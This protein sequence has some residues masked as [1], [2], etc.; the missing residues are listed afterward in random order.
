MSFRHP[1]SRPLVFHFLKLCTGPHN[2]C[3]WPASGTLPIFVT[4]RLQHST[5]FDKK[6]VHCEPAVGVY[7]CTHLKNETSGYSA[8]RKPPRN[9]GQPLVRL[10]K[11]LVLMGII[12]KRIGYQA[13]TTPGTAAP[14][15]N[16]WLPPK[17]GRLQGRRCSNS[18]SRPRPGSGHCRS[19]SRP[20]AGMAPAGAGELPWY[21]PTEAGVPAATTV[22]PKSVVA[23]PET[24]PAR[25]SGDPGMGR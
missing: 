23:V 20:T 11:Q 12:D 4:N 14:P 16:Q 15:A 22:P 5:I 19:N 6:N 25:N 13:N 10:D 21:N 3:G 9:N 2:A 18:C 1:F 8:K 7:P 24:A 17:T